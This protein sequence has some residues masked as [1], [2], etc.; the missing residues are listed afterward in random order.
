MAL[1]PGSP[2]LGAGVAAGA[3]PADQRGAARTPPP[4]AG[5]FEGLA[6]VVFRDGFASGDTTAWSSTTP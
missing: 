3:P 4:D 6:D 5:A 2:A 1:L